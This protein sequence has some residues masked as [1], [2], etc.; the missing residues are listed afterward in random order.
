MQRKN[1][2]GSKLTGG[3]GA[4]GKPEV[5]KGHTKTPKELRRVPVQI[6]YL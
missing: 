5:G 2:I 3:L 6:W 1:S 4:G